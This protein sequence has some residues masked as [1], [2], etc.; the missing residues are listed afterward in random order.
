[1]AP[2]IREWELPETVHANYSVERQN[3]PGIPEFSDKRIPLLSS[4][5]VFVG[6]TN[7]GKS[8]LL[9]SWFAK[10]QPN[11]IPGF[12]AMG[13]LYE[14]QIQLRDFFEDGDDPSVSWL[15]MLKDIPCILFD[16]FPCDYPGWSVYR[17]KTQD[18]PL[19]L[20]NSEFKTKRGKKLNKLTG[21]YRKNIHKLT[22]AIADKSENWPRLAYIPIL[23]SLRILD[24]VDHLGV[25]THK[26]YF[27]VGRSDEIFGADRAKDI[28]SHLKRQIITGQ[29]YYALVRSH[30]LGQLA[31]RRRIAE[32]EKFLGERFFNS[33][34]I[35]LI[36]FE[37]NAGNQD[38]LHIKIGDAR[39]RPIHEVGDGISQI[40]LLTL[41][42]F[43]LGDKPTI[44]V[45]EEPEMHLHMGLQRL[46]VEFILDGPHH[47]NRQ[48]FVTTHSQ[49]FLDMTLET[50][51][52]SVYRLTS[53][54][55]EL[56]DDVIETDPNFTIK[57]VSD[58]RRPLLRE[59]GIH[60]SSVL[61]AN[62][63][64]WVEGITDRL[65][66]RHFL[67]LYLE[68]LS[69]DQA[70][71]L[72]DIHFSFVEY[73]G[74]NMVHW[75]IAADDD[76]EAINVAYLCSSG[77]LICDSDG[78]AWKDDR[79]QRLQTKLGDRFLRLPVREIENLLSEKTILDVVRDYEEREDRE[80]IEPCG[81]FG[82][83]LID[84]PIGEYIEAVFFD[85]DNPSCR[86]SKSG[87]PYMA[88]SGTIKDKDGFCRKAIRHLKAYDE[89]TP[90][91][92]DVVKKIYEFIHSH[93]Q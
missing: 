23:R 63:T 77:F 58:D 9:R 35:A 72:E 45:I 89:L 60:N 70:R 15:I 90:H 3:L 34:P 37:D 91:A 61:L 17:V 82:Q 80:E 2:L 46:L 59:L 10:E 30:L 13:D 56:K 20:R 81:E 84:A 7:S 36:P 5:N 21:R 69:P 49:Q 27:S 92:Q 47:E 75:S 48:V 26:D 79:A 87:H 55:P 64:I 44:F 16:S 42:M 65:Y 93:Q 86:K 4:L 43:L 25:R 78:A 14:S 12:G 57:L 62:C 19:G 67:K 39:E 76:E 24:T 29:D 88:E 85:D 38:A 31:D 54:L 66:I 68:T 74:A 73:G 51:D 28:E 83:E 71:Y 41:P 22:D 50:S 32:Y 52:I 40:V 53:E 11:C 8:R 6:P 18:R 1:M 33:K